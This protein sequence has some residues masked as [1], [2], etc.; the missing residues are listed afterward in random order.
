MIAALRAF[1]IR[2]RGLWIAPSS[3]PGMREELAHDLAL[4]TEDG[5][6]RGLSHEEAR[7][8]ALLQLGGLEQT[9]QS[10]RDRRT[11]PSVEELLQDLRFAFRQLRHRPAFTL[12]AI[13]T[14]A[15]GF[16]ASIAI[17]AFVDAAMIKPLPYR[18][19][20]RLAWVTETVE[21]MG[22]ANLS[23]QDYQDWQRQNRSFESLAVWRYGGFQ[24]RI[25]EG[26]VFTPAMRV[27]AN[28]LSTLGVHPVAGRDFAATDNLVGAAKVVMISYELWRDIFHMD[29]DVVN[30]TLDFSGDKYTVIG[31]LPEKFQFAPRGRL[32]ALTAITP[33]QGYCEGR[34]S[35]HSLNGVARLKSGVTFQQADADVKAIAHNLESQYPDS[36]R[37]QGG[38]AMPLTE[39]IVRKIRPVFYV[40][41]SAALLLCFIACINVASLLLARSEGRRRE[42]AL[43]TALGATRRRMFRQF[44]TESI[45]LVLTGTITGIALALLSVRSIMLLVPQSMRDQMP[46]FDSVSIN[47]DTLFFAASIAIGAIILFTLIPGL[48]IS[49]NALQRAIAEGSAGAGSGSLSWNRVGSLL[50]IA[51]VAV[52]V[53]L[54]AGAGLLSRSLAN[55]LRTDLNFNPD[56]LVTVNVVP[57]GKKFPT[58]AA[59]IAMERRVVE[60][61]STLPGVTAAGFG[62][63]LPVTF[64]GNTDW[65]RF[66]DRP[67]D[68][69]HIEINGR[70]ASSTYL[71][72]LGVPLLKGRFISEQD[73]ADKP[74]VA[75]VNRH[76]AESYFPGQNPIGKT[77]GDTS[78]TPKSMKT[79]V[80]VIDDLHEGSLDDP[81]WPA[82]YYSAYQSVDQAAIVLRVASGESSIIASLPG[83]IRSV[84]PDL[85]M[86]DVMTMNDRINSS[87][88]ATL[89]R[90]AA[91]LAGAFAITALLLCAVGLYG[92]ISYSISL[93]TRE[94]GVRMAL[95]ARRESIYGMVLRE[96]GRLS[97]AG[98]LSGL[99]LSVLAASLLKSVLFG[100]SGWDPLTLGISCVVLGV[101]TFLASALPARRAATANPMEA[102]RTE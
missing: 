51:E 96:A 82:A 12:T 78:L 4:M 52:A 38:I 54:L 60:R 24:M 37:G 95:G 30:R 65:I 94:I 101:S 41:L 7:R 99:L 16:G 32:Q 9:M 73:T 44:A 55:L 11:L 50:V 19:P 64:N 93:R 58:D 100:V 25:G 43:R 75:V 61:L 49:W 29:P 18:E 23:W 80:G 22:P 36:N 15:L 2:L 62:S 87:Q 74:L 5:E 98:I 59:Q 85:G 45:T 72:A 71:Q 66:P 26:L 42:F 40:L 63:L 92:V 84:D 68:G 8:Q 6:L 35:C 10:V 91:W 86:S 70:S 102:L 27:S 77:F 48:R 76:F 3:E 69:K 1:F 17:F 81:I 56:H 89:H 88:S 90:G 33:E 34:R 46:F 47:R 79:I 53:V 57:P 97:L 14:L 31:V 13:F 39:Q 21:I 20:Q 67:Y 28:F 83:V